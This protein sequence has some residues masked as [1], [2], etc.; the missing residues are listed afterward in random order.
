MLFGIATMSLNKYYKIF[1]VVFG[2]VAM[3]GEAFAGSAPLPPA[4]TA[5]ITSGETIA[6]QGWSNFCRKYPADCNV[7][8]LH[9]KK[10]ALTPQLWSTIVEVNSSVNQAI[11]PVSDWSHWGV[12]ESWDYPN[13]GKGDCEDY[14]LMKRKILINAGIPRQS[15]MITV[16]INR[17]KEGHAVLMLATDLG[18]F[19]LD[20]QSETVLPWDQ[21]EYRYIERQS[22]EN[23]NIWVSL[24]DAGGEMVVASRSTDPDAE[25]QSA[26]PA[27]SKKAQ[28]GS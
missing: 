6:P 18:D 2:F 28:A 19:I 8:A 5:A 24:H 23:P 7:P 11:T 15:L 16:V 22:A 14:A 17:R 9:A 21:T 3:T 25:P 27:K 10:L 4:T 1:L 13:D 20:N 26:K 12:E